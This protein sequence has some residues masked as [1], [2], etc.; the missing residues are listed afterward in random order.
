MRHGRWQ[1]PMATLLFIIAYSVSTITVSGW[2]YNPTNRV[3]ILGTNHNR[4][5][6]DKQKSPRSDILS[7]LCSKSRGGCSD[8]DE[9]QAYDVQPIPCIEVPPIWAGKKKKALVLMDVFSEYHGMYLAHMAKT[10]YGVATINVFSDYFKGYFQMQQRSTSRN[11]DEEDIANF[12]QTM[13]MCMPTLT[14]PAAVNDWCQPLLQDFE[15]VAISCESDSG[16]ADAERLG[17]AL[18]VTKQNSLVINDARRNKYLMMEAVKKA[19]IPV[20]QQRLCA[21][22]DDAMEFCQQTLGLTTDDKDD[23]LVV[24]K[25]IRGV[26]SDDVHLCP[27]LD[28]VREAFSKIQ[29]STVFGSPNQIHDKVLVQEFAVG[30]EFA[31]D[32]VSKSGQH[33]VAAIWI[34]DKRPVN[35]A[36]FVYYSTKLYDG[37]LSTQ[38]V[39]H[40]KQCLDALKIEWGMTHT[41]IIITENG[42]RLVEVNCRQHNMDFLPLTMGGIGYNAF[43]MLL[44]AYL[45]SDDDDDEKY[46]SETASQRLDWNTLPDIPSTPHRMAAAMVHLVNSA[47][48]GSLSSVNENALMEIQ[49]MNSVL[50]LEVYGSFLEIGTVI[51]PTIDIRSDAGWVQLVNPDPD[52]LERDYVRIVELMPTLFQVEEE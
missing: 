48:T 15:L 13:S 6:C 34:Y 33:K 2:R 1:Y 42:P 38:I 21:T 39:E 22:L 7:L 29:G 52:A 44:A 28:S 14:S 9:K 5:Y 19:G 11:K 45:G 37:E 10:A 24:V 41:E 12:Q 32:I 40:A 30:Q 46:P 17:I 23:Q 27:T 3:G 8:Q 43:D 47:P 18:N 31:I 50:D 4:N 35:N 26:A 51:T 20:V 36:P 16:L 25:P 49:S